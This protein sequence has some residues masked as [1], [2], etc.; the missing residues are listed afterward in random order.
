MF[1]FVEGFRKVEENQSVCYVNSINVLVNF[2]QNKNTMT[3]WY[4]YMREICSNHL[5]RQPLKIGGPGIRVQ[6]DETVVSRRKNH[7]GRVIPPRWVFGGIDE[8]TKIG[9]LIFVEN[10]S[11][12]TLRPL[13]KK[14]I[15]EGSIIISDEWAA[16]RGI[17]N[18]DGMN[19]THM[20]VN[21]SQNFVDPTTGV[22]TNLRENMWKNCKIKFKK[23]LAVHTTMLTSYIDEFMWRQS[24]GNDAFNNISLHVSNWLL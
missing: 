17:A 18:I 5:T 20:T 13:I 23:I 1:D 10:R 24:Y 6:I 15:R 12:S 21:H 8:T 11:S 4:S 3:Q 16:Y 7:Q 2:R 19:Y 9:F 14:H 22:H